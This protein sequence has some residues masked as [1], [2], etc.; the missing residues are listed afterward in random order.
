MMVYNAF[1]KYEIDCMHTKDILL[2]I[3][4]DDSGKLREL[5]DQKHLCP[6]TGMLNGQFDA[7]SYAVFC[8]AF[9]CVQVM[10]RFGFNQT[11]ASRP[12][13]VYAP[14]SLALLRG[15]YQI[16]GLLTLHLS[17]NDLHV[18]EQIQQLNLEAQ[19]QS[20]QRQLVGD[21]EMIAASFYS[22]MIAP[23]E[24]LP[25]ILSY[26]RSHASLQASFQ[27]HLHEG[28]VLAAHI[29]DKA[30]LQQILRLCTSARKPTHFLRCPV[31][32]AANHNNS[33]MIHTLLRAGY[34]LHL[35]RQSVLSTLNITVALV[36]ARVAKEQAAAR[37]TVLDNTSIDA[38]V[39]LIDQ[40]IVANYG[41]FLLPDARPSKDYEQFK[42]AIATNQLIVFLN[43][44]Q[45]VTPYYRATLCYASLKND[46]HD[47]ATM[48]LI[49]AANIDSYLLFT[50]KQLFDSNL[51]ASIDDDDDL[52]AI[53]KNDLRKVISNLQSRH[54]W[55]FAAFIK[56]MPIGVEVSAMKKLVAELNIQIPTKQDAIIQEILHAVSYGAAFAVH[57]WLTK[58]VAI[59]TNDTLAILTTRAQEQ[60]PKRKLALLLNSYLP[61]YQQ[62]LSLDSIVALQT[63]YPL[64]DLDNCGPFS[65]IGILP[66]DHI[67]SYL[68]ADDAQRNRP[69]NLNALRQVNRDFK[70]YLNTKTSKTFQLMVRHTQT[71]ALLGIVK[72]KIPNPMYETV[73]ANSFQCTSALATSACL[74]AA[75]CIVLLVILKM[76]QKMHTEQNQPTT[77][78]NTLS[79]LSSMM[80]SN[81][82]TTFVP[83][84]TDLE[85]VGVTSTLIGVGGFGLLICLGLIGCVRSRVLDNR[86]RLS[87]YNEVLRTS[88]IR[89]L[90]AQPPDAT[91]DTLVRKLVKLQFD[92]ENEM[93]LLK[94]VPDEVHD[95]IDIMLS[96][97]ETTLIVNRPP[98]NSL[99]FFAPSVSGASSSTSQPYLPL[100]RDMPCSDD[101]YSENDIEMGLLP[102]ASAQLGLQ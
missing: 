74:V 42:K 35:A 65:K 87:N 43:L 55:S 40:E 32:W 4:A 96:P 100:S 29:N 89:H 93:T 33:V 48:L 81:S 101:E 38:P 6:Q 58:L 26:I 30:K 3:K 98:R 80:T 63:A 75:V 69:T 97:Q 90:G 82:T 7:L 60:L 45:S 21:V 2:V 28:V 51:P 12:R 46:D 91:L 18:R 39:Q 15:N 59:K 76:P 71:R 24:N 1:F 49:F 86:D 5:I 9:R 88:I 44:L 52:A 14:L 13:E 94:A 78:W 99:T 102:P 66:L 34:S 53:T 64:V 79:T 27:A 62:S 95:D 22:A 17:D 70:E 23:A 16:A 37:N 36:V 31:Y 84:Y 47:L 56:K 77:E 68:I 19:W 92:D 72:R 85:T 61:E 10:L 25:Q 83:D 20:V 57:F 73:L 8:D 50:I 41:V 11:S 54:H 67:L